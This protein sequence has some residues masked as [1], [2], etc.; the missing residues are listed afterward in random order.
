LK[1]QENHEQAWADYIRLCKAGGSKGFLDLVELAGLEN[2]FLDG[3]M[4]KIAA[5][6]TD[7][8]AE[9]A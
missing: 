5:K 4:E 8:L 1:D 9:L 7:R 2:P 3:V 6:V